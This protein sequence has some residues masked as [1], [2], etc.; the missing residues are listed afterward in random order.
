LAEASKIDHSTWLAALSDPVRL[1]VLQA[2]VEL[3]EASAMEL[4]RH[5]HVSDPTLRRHLQAL[6]ALGVVEEVPGESDGESPGRPASR[7]R[8]DR[9]ARKRAEALLALLAEPLG[10]AP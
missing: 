8:L 3:K 4:S 10:P 9:G 5:S 1:A 7:F 6:G 2:L